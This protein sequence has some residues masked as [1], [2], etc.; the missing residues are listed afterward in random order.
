M[1][2]PYISVII[3]AYNRKKYLLGA[4]QSALDQTLPKDLYEIIVVKNFRDKAIDSK[5]Q[6]LGVVN[7]YSDHH[8]LG[9]K[10]VE[11]LEVG[12]GDVIS[13]LE[14]DDEFLPGKLQ[15]VYLSFK[16]KGTL[17]F[18]H[19][20]ELFIDEAG[21][22]LGK[23]EYPE[24]CQGFVSYAEKWRYLRLIENCPFKGNSFISIR[25]DV[26]LRRAEVLKQLTPAVDAY[27]LSSAMLYGRDLLFD[28]AVLTAYRLY[29]GQNMF[30][31]AG[32]RGWAF[33]AYA[34]RMAE[35]NLWFFRDYSLLLSMS[36]G[37]PYE[38]VFR[39]IQARSKLASY[40]YW[41]ISSSV[42]PPDLVP[43]VWDYLALL[44]F[45]PGCRGL[46]CFLELYAFMAAC[47]SPKPVRRLATLYEF[48][49]NRWGLVGARHQG[50]SET[51]DP[52]ADAN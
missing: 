41:S 14:D 19:N 36:R 29:P 39:S 49:R 33:P 16:A 45:A 4:V 50:E 38:A 6:E 12:K 23:R 31:Q 43:N 21:N 40:L 9:A 17:D 37:T 3:T 5:L 1:G 2:K 10:I 35:R 11:A 15:R 18:Y 52:C 7:L 27:C 51:R 26:L 44:R 42:V 20:R 47:A 30:N 46:R 28:S 13:F 34:R 25:R 8:G 32:S 22:R 24:S 48:A